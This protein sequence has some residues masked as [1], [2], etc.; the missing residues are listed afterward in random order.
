MNL[1]IIPNPDK[2]IVKEVIS[3]LKETGGQCPCVPPPFWNDDTK[4]QCKNFREQDYEGECHC[5]LWIKVIDD[6]E[7]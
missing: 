7:S 4:C 3:K 2:E 6:E 1:K 5:G